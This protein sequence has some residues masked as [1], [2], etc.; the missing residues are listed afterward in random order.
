MMNSAGE[1]FQQ[2]CYEMGVLDDDEE[3]GSAV[4]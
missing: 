4:G 3:P 1:M 2:Y